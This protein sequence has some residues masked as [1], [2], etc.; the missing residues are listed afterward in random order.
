MGAPSIKRKQATIEIMEQFSSEQVRERLAGWS[1]PARA[2]QS[3]LYALLDPFFDSFAFEPS[4]KLDLRDT[5]PQFF[6]M[7]AWERVTYEPPRLVRVPPEGLSTLLDGLSTERWGVFVVSRFDLKELAAHFSRFVIARGPDGSPYFLRF[8]DASVLGVLLSTWTPADR[9]KFFGPCDAFGLTD[10]AQVEVRLVESPMG[11]RQRKVPEPE[12]CLLDLSREQLETCG[13]AIERDLVH[14]LHW[15]LRNHHA[16]VVQ[17]IDRDVLERRIQVAIHKARRYGFQTVSDLA[18]FSALMF[19]LAPNFDEHPTFLKV[20][21]DRELPSEMK[22]RRLSQSIS[23][24]D[25]REASDR[26]DRTFWL[27][28]SV[29][30]AALR[31][32]RSG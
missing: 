1:A 20:L 3:Q 29:P 13:Q 28:N 9:A 19:E 30:S 11:P 2:G 14:V 17:H 5:D 23:E 18:G 12:A 21:A 15:H 31:R 22:L 25:W 8:H 32:R 10:L 16:K 24:K 27:K 4:V 7:I 26:Y 6:E